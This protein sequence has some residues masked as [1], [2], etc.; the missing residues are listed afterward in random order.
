M[1]SLTYFDQ[2][3]LPEFRHTVYLP[4]QD[5]ASPITAFTRTYRMFHR[6]SVSRASSFR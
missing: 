2:K 6:D 1:D 5:F 4:Y 3:S